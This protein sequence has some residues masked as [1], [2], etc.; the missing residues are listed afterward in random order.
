M[1]INSKVQLVTFNG[2]LFSP[3]KCDPK[4]NYWALIGKTGFVIEPQNIR[5]RV[6]VQFEE[7]LCELGLTSHNPK[8]NSLLILISDLKRL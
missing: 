8:P 1:D 4:E 2:L 7:N 5:K 3:D 6:L